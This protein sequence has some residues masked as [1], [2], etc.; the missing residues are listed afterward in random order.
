MHKKLSNQS[1]LLLLQPLEMNIFKR[2]SYASALRDDVITY[3]ED[4][5]LTKDK[6]FIPR[7]DYLEMLQ[8][9]LLVLG[10]SIPNYKFHVPHACSHSRWMAKII[11]SMKI[12]LFR[13]QVHLTKGEIK[14]LE[15]IC[16]FICLIYVKPW[17][18]CCITSNAPYNDLQLMKELVR[19]SKINKEISQ[20]AV[21]KFNDHLWYLGSELVVLSLFS[22]KVTDIVKHRLFE[23]MKMV[24]K[25]KWGERSWR[26]IDTKNIVEKDLDDLVGDS[27]MSALK[28]LNMDIDFMFR[29]HVSNWK[30]LDEYKNAKAIVDSLKVT[31]DTAE[32]SLKLM[33]DI[34]ESL[35]SKENKMQQLIQVI[36]DNRKRI[37][38][39][40]KDTLSSYKRCRSD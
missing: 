27:S 33:T 30:N 22:N 15:D 24:D 25:G 19:Y 6:N 26:L 35:T 20:H 1:L 23:K 32:R 9:T 3:I 18:Q 5:L 29:N 7:A 10:K 40:K 16:L 17:I 8:L 4:I 38:N 13:R 14:R 12:F 21:K 36:E 34:N 2:S 39:T 37:P 28:S 11:Y 31:N